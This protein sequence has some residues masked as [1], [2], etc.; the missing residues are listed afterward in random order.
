MILYLYIRTSLIKSPSKR[1]DKMKKEQTKAT[2]F[3]EKIKNIFT[4]S[5]SYFTA[6]TLALLII[7]SFS[8]DIRYITPIRFLLIY[9]FSFAMAL[10]NLVLRSKSIK[11]FAKIM[12][13]YL[14]SIASFYI[15][16][17]LPAKNSGSPAVLLLTLTF[18]YFVIATPILIIRHKQHKKEIEVTPY[19]SVYTKKK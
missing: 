8:A 16:L 14:I 6:I 3:F 19:I 18:V 9:P 15:F 7:Q 5:C 1:N 10:G 12:Y 13:H 4:S 17:V 11:P 2:P